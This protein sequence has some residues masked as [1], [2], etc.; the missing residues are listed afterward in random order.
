M[1]RRQV[2]V[3]VAR[4]PGGGVE[5]KWEPATD[6]LSDLLRAPLD[7]LNPHYITD[8]LIIRLA[9][10]RI[11]VGE[12]ARVIGDRDEATV[13]A[14]IA[15]QLAGA[16]ESLSNLKDHTRCEG[17]P[18]RRRQLIG[19]VAEYVSALQRD[20]SWDSW[21]AAGGKAERRLRQIEGASKRPGDKSSGR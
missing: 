17:N 10:G 2:H 5:R 18:K 15:D 20:H 12:V 11:S 3:A 1:A 8:R 7:P 16:C 6:I 14:A 9:A 4:R 21:I 13:L 19:A